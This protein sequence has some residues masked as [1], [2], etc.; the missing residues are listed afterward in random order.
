MGRKIIEAG[1]K[2]YQKFVGPRPLSKTAKKDIERQKRV[3][4]KKRDKEAGKLTKTEK[5]QLR[6]AENR[7]LK[8]EYGTTNPDII[9]RM[10]EGR[11]LNALEKAKN[12]ERIK[13]AA[14]YTSSN[15][16]QAAWGG[17]GPKPK[18][19]YKKGGML[20][21]PRPKNVKKRTPGGGRTLTEKEKFNI[22]MQRAKRMRDAYRP[23][24]PKKYKKGGSVKGK[25][26][27][28][29]IAIRGKTRAK[30]K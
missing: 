4:A 28:D 26:K 9:K 8:T 13:K 3:A 21:E 16:S 25:C 23:S 24:G 7:K 5:L 22:K 15:K 14:P 2:L 10:K 30:R 29:G 20:K 6:Q 17:Y 12:E 27:I 11:K 18:G 1:K 19:V